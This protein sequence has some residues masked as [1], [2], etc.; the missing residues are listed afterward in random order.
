MHRFLIACLTLLLALP[1][2]AADPPAPLPRESLYQLALPLTDQ[3]GAH[4]DWRSLRGTPRVVGMFYTSCQ[5]T[6]PL[7]VESGKAIQKQLT[8]AQ[9]ERLG[10]VLISMDPQRDTPE[11]LQRV[12]ARHRV[13]AHWTLAAPRAADVRAVAG[14]LGVRY[15]QLADGD[16]NHTAALV[17]LDSDGR[18]LARTE[19]IGS[20]PDPAFVAA[21]R[22]ATSR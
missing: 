21:V 17:L 16:F 3:H 15:R 14:V 13:D 10:M 11:A 18:E 6:C 9:R 4:Y 2:L 7:I 1:A 19:D 22:K 12:A 8:S 20:V 5:F